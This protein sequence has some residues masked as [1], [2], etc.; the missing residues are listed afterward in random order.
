[1]ADKMTVYSPAAVKGLTKK[2]GFKVIWYL[3]IVSF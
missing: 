2:L 1:M 3:K